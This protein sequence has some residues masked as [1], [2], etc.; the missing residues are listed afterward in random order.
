VK[1]VVVGER[2]AV[3]ISVASRK[4]ATVISKS[5]RRGYWLVEWP[6][7]EQ[8]EISSHQMVSP[9][10]DHAVLLVRYQ[11]NMAKRLT[12]EQL[13][14]GARCPGCQ[15]PIRGTRPDLTGLAVEVLRQGLREP[16][17]ETTWEAERGIHLA[18]DVGE[19]M[20]RTD[21]GWVT[22]GAG[23]VALRLHD[24]DEQWA[25][26]HADELDL[27]EGSSGWRIAGGPAH[28]GF[29]CP[30]PPLSPEQIARIAAILRSGTGGGRWRLAM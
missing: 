6:D 30:P 3:G 16:V 29:C 10:A 17:A 24:E 20:R 28:C 7:G 12:W 21:Q 26:R 25:A 27:H 2:Y 22:T 9:W 1:G 14:A 11:D 18:T 15:R 5:G 19:F 4:P 23:A 8:G 13:Q